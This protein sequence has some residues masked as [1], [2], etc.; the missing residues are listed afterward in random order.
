MDLD[1]PQPV[2]AKVRES[3]RKLT[4]AQRGSADALLVEHLAWLVDTDPSVAAIKELRSALA[5][6]VGEDTGVPSDPVDEV[7]RQRESRKAR[8]S[9]A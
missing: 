5:V 3:L 9:G 4:P 1:Q 7:T 6:M 8:A 2:L